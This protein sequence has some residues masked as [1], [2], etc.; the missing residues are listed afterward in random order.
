MDYELEPIE[1]VTYHKRSEYDVDSL[2]AF[3]SDLKPELV[4]VVGW[5]DKGYLRAIMNTKK[6]HNIC[7]VSGTDDQW[8]R[9]LKQ[10]FGILVFKFF[11]KGIFDFMW[12][13]GKPQYHFCRMMGY[14][15]DRI[16]P[17]LLSASSEDFS[18]EKVNFSKR[19]VCLGRIDLNKNVHGLIE[20]FKR[21]DEKIKKEWPLVII[22]GGEKKEELE[23]QAD[24]FIQFLPFMQ[25]DE[26]KAEMNKGGVLC[27]P[28]FFESWGLVIHEA[29]ML[30]YPLLI[31]NSAGARSE[32]LLNGYNG[33]S[34][35]VNEKDGLY[36]GL[37]Q[38][39]LLGDEELLQFSEK[40][41]FLSSRINSDLAASSFISALYIKDMIKS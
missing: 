35:D 14:S 18:V 8:Y 37:K 16:L 41:K 4:Y 2:T 31:S 26:L 19:I 29:A 40:S 34:V 7:V 6:K 15:D 25:G 32:F 30:G 28:T 10:Y 27:V 23:K 20:A 13:P 5:M 11:L 1:G 36:N 24:E 21:L 39:T 17:N 22:G 12:V 3:I 38:I 9:T 33:Y